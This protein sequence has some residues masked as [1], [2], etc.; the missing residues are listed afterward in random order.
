M[1]PCHAKLVYF[2][3]LKS[4]EADMARPMLGWRKEYFAH[5]P[6]VKNLVARNALYNYG[7][8][9]EVWLDR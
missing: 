2:H 9:Q 8:M 3:P 5:W 1:G 4:L 6:H 7:R